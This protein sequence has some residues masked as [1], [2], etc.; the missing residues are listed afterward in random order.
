M[1]GGPA[2]GQRFTVANGAS[3][4]GGAVEVSFATVAIGGFSTHDASMGYFNSPLIDMIA[5][6]FMLL[7][8]VNFSLHFIAFR[9]RSVMGYW[10]DSEFR[11]YVLLLSLV[12]WYLRRA[13]R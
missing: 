2:A 8:G 5:V 9:H 1:A 3:Y 11:F 13:Q 12:I 7:A 10:Y 4:S 6:V